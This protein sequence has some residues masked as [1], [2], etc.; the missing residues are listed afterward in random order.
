MA[1]K[2]QKK[3]PFVC[4]KGIF[5]YFLWLQGIVLDLKIKTLQ[6]IGKVLQFLFITYSELEEQHSRAQ[7]I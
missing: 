2:Q 7:A 1:A 6:I 3:N 4:S 5:Q